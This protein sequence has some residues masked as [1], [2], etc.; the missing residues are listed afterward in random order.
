MFLVLLVFAPKR[1]ASMRVAAVGFTNTPWGKA[2]A[3]FRITDAS[4]NVTW[5]IYA[6]LQKTDLDWKSVPT[7]MTWSS[8]PGSG[9]HIIGVQVP[10][11]NRPWRVVLFCQ[12]RCHGFRGLLDR[13]K[14]EYERRVTRMVRM[15]FDG[16]KYCVTNDFG[17]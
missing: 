17:Q 15:R 13:A 5:N 4:P 14:E 11:T 3:L 10:S 1:P 8:Y 2:E 12:E 16:P 7:P 9:G 6:L